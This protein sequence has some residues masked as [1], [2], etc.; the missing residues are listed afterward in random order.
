[1]GIEPSVGS[2]GDSY[3]NA[4]AESVIGLFKTE[5]IR[6]R[7]PWRGI[8]GVEFA[9]RM[10][11]LVQQPP[12]A[13]TTGNVPPAE[14]EARYYAQP[15]E[16]ALPRTQPNSLRQTW[17]GS[18]VTKINELVALAGARRRWGALNSAPSFTRRWTHGWRRT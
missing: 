14:A 6:R 9:T 16:T 15:Q 18:T 11:G 3:D 17:R 8:E 4:L 12:T 13:R 1:M 5:V 2:V 10:G 7:V